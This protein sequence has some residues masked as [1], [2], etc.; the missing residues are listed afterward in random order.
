MKVRLI[1]IQQE[2]LLS[3]LGF[4]LETARINGQ[5]GQIQ[6]T[7]KLIINQT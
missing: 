6:L 4:G 1:M 7:L 2:T 5:F 3:N